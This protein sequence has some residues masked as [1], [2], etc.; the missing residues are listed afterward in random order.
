MATPSVG[1]VVLVRFPFSDLS[2]SK[3]RPAFVLADVGRG[4]HLL[5]Q[6]TSRRYS[7]F[8]AIE[9]LDDDFK[10]GSLQ[11][12]SYIRPEKLFTA[13]RTLIEREVGLLEVAPWQSVVTAI[14]SI[15][16]KSIPEH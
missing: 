6:I 14:E 5:C 13:N 11:R 1:A 4:D 3:L 7:D 15:L 12:R 16:R 2:D 8:T 10:R 9:L